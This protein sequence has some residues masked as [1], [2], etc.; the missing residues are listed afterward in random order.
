MHASG[1]RACPRTISQYHLP[2]CSQAAIGETQ[3]AISF[4]QMASA[5]RGFV[6]KGQLLNLIQP[7]M[8]IQSK[9]R[10]TVEVDEIFKQRAKSFLEELGPKGVTLDFRI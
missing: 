8:S 7:S 1:T 6:A 10:P 4:Q 2:A 5:T 9:G 3:K